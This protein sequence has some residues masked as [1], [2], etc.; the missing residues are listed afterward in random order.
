MAFRV[1]QP[2]QHVNNT[3]QIS[4]GHKVAEEIDIEPVKMKNYKDKFL[5][6]PNQTRSGDVEIIQ[7]KNTEEYLEK[8]GPFFHMMEKPEYEKEEL[9]YDNRTKE[10]KL[11]KESELY[12]YGS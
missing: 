6:Y 10:W 7:P 5:Y 4:E 11:I 2:V 3:R 1:R 8:F 9:I 12:K